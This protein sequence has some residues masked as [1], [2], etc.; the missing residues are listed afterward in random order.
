DGPVSIPS[1]PR[2]PQGWDILDLSGLEDLEP[3]RRIG[4]P[5]PDG[6]RGPRVDH[7]SLDDDASRD[8]PIEEA[9]QDVVAADEHQI[10]Q[11]AH[12]A[13]RDHQGLAYLKSSR[14]ARD[15]SMS[16]S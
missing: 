4:G 12:V 15:S 9:R 5:Q 3:P 1:D 8:D 10:M 14:P 11:R 13:G 6:F 7:L 16:R 2:L